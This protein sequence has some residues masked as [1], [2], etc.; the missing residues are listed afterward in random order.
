MCKKK[1]NREKY[2][3]GVKITLSFKIEN[4][5]FHFRLD[6]MM[7]FR[8]FNFAFFST[9]NVRSAPAISHSNKQLLT[10]HSGSRISK[11]MNS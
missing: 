2:V 8:I 7:L 3:T 9:K 4:W 6:H 10:K 5:H 11:K 1:K